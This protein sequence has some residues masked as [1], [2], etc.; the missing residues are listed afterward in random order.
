[1]TEEERETELFN[2]MERRNLLKTRYSGKW[3]D[4]RSIKMFLKN[5]RKVGM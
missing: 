1:M 4:S 5:I 2:R 3:F